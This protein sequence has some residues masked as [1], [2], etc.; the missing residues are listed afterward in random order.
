MGILPCGFTFFMW[1]A[2]IKAAEMKLAQT[3]NM[4][5]FEKIFLYLATWYIWGRNWRK[6]AA[7]SE[8]FQ[9]AHKSTHTQQRKRNE[10][11]NIFFHPAVL[12]GFKAHINTEILHIEKKKGTHTHKTD[13][14]NIYSSHS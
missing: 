1:A 11:L 5:Y 8:A 6:A 2:T 4:G 3:A 7:L 10:N 12:G 9:T 13:G 14:H